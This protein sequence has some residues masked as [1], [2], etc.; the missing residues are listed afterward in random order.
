MAL[1]LVVSLLGQSKPTPKSGA[2]L[3]VFAFVLKLPVIG[4]SAY[5][6]NIAGP[7][8]IWGFVAGVLLVYSAVVW[9]AARSS[10]F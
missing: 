4:V 5:V 7:G 9:R 8:G 1:Y 6:S 10:L 2:S 3:T